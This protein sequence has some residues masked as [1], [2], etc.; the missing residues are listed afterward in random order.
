[1]EKIVYIYGLSKRET[2]KDFYYIGKSIRPRGRNDGKKNLENIIVTILDRFVDREHYWIHKMSEEG[3][4]LENK[5]RFVGQEFH[6]IGDVIEYRQHRG[7]RI[8]LRNKK[9][10]ITY[11]SIKKA[12]STQ[13]KY[14]FDYFYQLLRNGKLVEEWERIDG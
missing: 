14:T 2:P 9:T 12:H 8:R 3:H 11:P 7:K 10:N 13:D 1:M 6:N 4:I 5:E